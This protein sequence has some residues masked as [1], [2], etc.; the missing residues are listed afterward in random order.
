MKRNSR[1]MR[2]VPAPQYVSANKRLA[3]LRSR[4]VDGLVAW[5]LL[6]TFTLVGSLGFCYGSYV[7][8][9]RHSSIPLEVLLALVGGGGLILGVF[10][11][12]RML[13]CSRRID[14]LD[15]KNRQ[16]NQLLAG[17][18]STGGKRGIT[19]TDKLR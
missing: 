11:L 14:E 5:L 2:P 6:G 10:F 19:F 1:R 13:L 12:R 9:A 15:E 3:D 8:G 7:I 16:R 4:E 17:V 18:L